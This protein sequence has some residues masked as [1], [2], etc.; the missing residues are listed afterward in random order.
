M[1]L[2]AVYSCGFCEDGN[3]NMEDGN[4]NMNEIVS[5]TASTALGAL[6][7]L[8]AGIANVQ[9]TMVKKS[10]KPYLRMLKDGEWVYGQEDIE[11]ETG[12]LWA[13]NPFSIEHGWTAWK[14]GEG[15]DNSGGP[16]GEVMVP[17]SQPCP[18]KQTLHDVGADWE[19]QMAVE[20]KCLNGTD[21][22]EE[23]S[24]KASSVGAS[25]AMDGL[26]KAIMN[27]LD[28][29]EEMP[30]PIVSLD[31]LTYNHKKYGKTYEPVITIKEWAPLS[32]T[33][34]EVDEPG[35]TAADPAPAVTTTAK[36][37]TRSVPAT[38]S[39]APTPVPGPVEED[40]EIAKLEKMILAKKMAKEQAVQ[41]V[42]DPI[43]ARKAALLA[44]MAALEAGETQAAQPEA[45][46][47][48]APASG[49][50]LRRRRTT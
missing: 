26:I 4:V 47:A 16:L 11:V 20:L 43:A 44:E 24:Y 18:P 17:M 41:P 8:K 14:R 6:K 3:V 40:D 12:S 23:V 25:K 33:P 9:Q 30:V 42:D 7:S 1:R 32:D 39:D 50:P 29:N 10:G 31:S 34:P 28:A 38:K 21:K 15:V 45:A 13:V 46:Q 35:A 22:G 48:E 27:Q 19:Y 5:R 37:R 36:P 49:Q 2:Q